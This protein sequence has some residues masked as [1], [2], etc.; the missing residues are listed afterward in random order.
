MKSEVRIIGTRTKI[1]ITLGFTMAISLIVSMFL[2][3]LAWQIMLFTIT[4]ATGI[5]IIGNGLVWIAG[6]NHQLK[7]MSI[8]RKQARYLSI[9]HTNNVVDSSTGEVLIR[10][11]RLTKDDAPIIEGEYEEVTPRKSALE[12]IDTGYHFLMVGDTGSGKSTLAAHFINQIGVK[13][14]IVCDPHATF[15]E[16]P[17]GVKIVQ[18]YESIAT[19]LMKIVALM[20]K[21]YSTG[22]NGNLVLVAIDELPAIIDSLHELG[23]D[24]GKWIRRLSREGRKANI[25]LLIMSQGENVGDLG[26]KGYSSVKL[27]FIK[28]LLSKADT[29]HNVAKVVYSNGDRDTV[30]L[31]GPLHFNS[32]NKILSLPAPST[33][34]T[35]CAN[36]DCNNPVKEGSKYCEANYMACKQAVYRLSR[37]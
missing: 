27:N 16:W 17:Y 34:F 32:S 14:T 20:D 15:N 11:T 1:I 22:D 36:P 30:T 33:S 8:E 12:L 23:Y 24:C 5:Y 25:R 3:P 28:V 19:V 9:A 21:R 4:G 18:D 35:K 7:M 31:H 13:N 37:V 26:Q 2:F 29:L 10:A 6:I